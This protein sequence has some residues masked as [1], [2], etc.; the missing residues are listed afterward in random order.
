MSE[1]VD[2]LG[3][4]AKIRQNFQDQFDKLDTYK[5]RLDEIIDSLK[6]DYNNPRIQNNLEI[7]RTD[8]IEYIKNLENQ[9]D[10]NFYIIKS[11][12]ILEDYKK[13]LKIPHKISFMGKT[14]KDNR[15]K[16]QLAQQFIDIASDYVNIDIDTN[17]KKENI[18]CPNC[19]NKKDFDIIEQ[20][21]YICMKCFAQQNIIK[22]ISSYNDIDRINI[23]SKYMYDRKVHFRDCIKQYQGKQNSNYFT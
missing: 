15:I 9:I 8:L 23:S 2:I 10:Y 1:Q 7:A 22:N 20:N 16:T 3:I 17:S 11:S 12:P 21:T 19:H 14:N 18:S 6:M 5:L 13:I 4:D